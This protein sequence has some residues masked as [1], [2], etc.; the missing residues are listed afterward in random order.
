MKK[1]SMVDRT[2]S[3]NMRYVPG[4]MVNLSIAKIKTKDPAKEDRENRNQVVKEIEERVNRGVPIQEA[5]NDLVKIYKDKFEYLQ[6]GNL[7]QIFAK[8]YNGRHKSKNK[9]IEDR[10]W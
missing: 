1:Y 7:A 4:T 10:T 6:N 5:C 2:S 3:S 9:S 8:W